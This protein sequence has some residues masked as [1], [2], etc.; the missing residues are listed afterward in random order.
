MSPRNPILLFSQRWMWTAALK[1]PFASWHYVAV[2][3]CNS[4]FARR[5]NHQN[6]ASLWKIIS[7]FFAFFAKRIASRLWQ[8]HEFSW[9]D[10]LADPSVCGPQLASAVELMELAFLKAIQLLRWC[11]VGFLPG[12]KGKINFEVNIQKNFQWSKRRTFE[13]KKY[14]PI[15]PKSVRKENEMFT[16]NCSLSAFEQWNKKIINHWPVSEEVV[17]FSRC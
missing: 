10:K 12:G 11:V 14:C 16:S 2:F 3:E 15:G 5:K 4:C 9:S 6:F 13:Q 17:K 1:K 7:N 8:N